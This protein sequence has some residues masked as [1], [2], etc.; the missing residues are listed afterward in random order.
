MADALEQVGLAGRAQWPFAALSGGQKQRVLIARALAT[1]PDLLVMDE[2]LAGVDLHSQAGLAQLLGGLRDGGLGLLVVLHERGP[3]GDVLD[4]TI[5][6]CDGRVVTD[7]HAH[8]A[9][10]CLPPAEP[11][12]VGLVDP[13]A[14][15]IS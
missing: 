7:E 2:P 5:T 6:L 3:M 9:D 11:S 12:A 8:A 14:G 15:A 1:R 13:I 4:R 10:D